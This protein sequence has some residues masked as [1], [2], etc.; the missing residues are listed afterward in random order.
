MKLSVFPL[1][2]IRGQRVSSF[3]LQIDNKDLIFNTPDSFQRFLRISGIKIRGKTRFMFTRQTED[4][5][6]GI[7]GFLLTMI[8]QKKQEQ[9]KLYMPNNLM[10]FIYRGRYLFGHRC[11][12][13]AIGSI[14]PPSGRFIRKGSFWTSSSLCESR[15]F[16]GDFSK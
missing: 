8:A 13:Y 12:N 10:H 1:N 9:T 2:C 4:S 16:V 11:V 14:D 15:R 5:F 6:Y 7:L 3:R